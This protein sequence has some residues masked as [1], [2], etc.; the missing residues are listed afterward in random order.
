MWLRET[1]RTRS[2][3]RKTIRLAKDFYLANSWNQQQNKLTQKKGTTT[4]IDFE[5]IIII[6]FRSFDV[7]I[8][9]DK[10]SLHR[11]K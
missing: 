3:S 9:Q 1:Q 7:T 6:V 5:F 4:V 8:Q 10:K 2:S 11:E